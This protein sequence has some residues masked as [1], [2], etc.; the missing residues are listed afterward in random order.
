MK[1]PAPELCSTV[2]HGHAEGQRDG[3]WSYAAFGTK[4][5]CCWLAQLI[6]VCMLCSALVRA[7]S[8]LLA[9][10]LKNTLECIAFYSIVHYDK[11]RDYLKY[12]RGWA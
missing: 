1:A 8:F 10:P 12:V 11:C 3:C 6:K 7:D 4:V 5:C 2:G 9:S